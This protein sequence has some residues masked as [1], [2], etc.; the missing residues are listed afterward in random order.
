LESSWTSLRR[1]FMRPNSLMFC[2]SSHRTSTSGMSSAIA[3]GT[4]RIQV[5]ETTKSWLNT[6]R[7]CSAAQNTTKR[8]QRQ[9]IQVSKS[10]IGWSHSVTQ[11]THHDRW[12]WAHELMLRI[13]RWRPASLRLGGAPS[14]PPGRSANTKQN[15]MVTRT[16]MQKVQK[17]MLLV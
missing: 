7:S 5:E 11:Q 17:S 16:R 2:W 6:H 1:W 15:I 12:W 13:G 9:H 3:T 10:R 8:Q 4:I 14:P